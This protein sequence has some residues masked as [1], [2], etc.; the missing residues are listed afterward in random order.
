MLLAS[1]SIKL[2]PLK[3]LWAAPLCRPLRRAAV[4]F[5]YGG[6]LGCFGR[7]VER[8]TIKRH[9]AFMA[10][11]WS[12]WTGW[13]HLAANVGCWYLGPHWHL[14][15]DQCEGTRIVFWW[16]LTAS[17]QWDLLLCRLGLAGTK[18]IWP[19]N[20]LGHDEERA[21]ASKP[22]T[23]CQALVKWS[24]SKSK[25]RFSLWCSCRKNPVTIVTMLQVEADWIWIGAT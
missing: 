24:K 17:E 25:C 2:G 16:V 10:L 18:G 7:V 19:E 12:L 13:H 9:G 22:G 23:I 1:F 8:E 5:G 14:R 20:C 15:A 21:K 6:A 11:A 3:G 4:G